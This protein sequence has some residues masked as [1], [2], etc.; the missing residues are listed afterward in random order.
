MAFEVSSVNPLRRAAYTDPAIERAEQQLVFAGGWIALL[1]AHQLSDSGDQVPVEAAGLPLVAVRDRDGQVRVFHNVCRHRASLVVPEPVKQQPT[2]RCPYHG[3]AYALDGSLRATPLWDGQRVTGAGVLDRLRLGLR[4]VRSGVWSDVVWIDLSGTAPPFEEHVAPL[5]R[6]WEGYDMAQFRVAHTESGQIDANWKL[7][8]EA[9]VENYH[10]SF[11]HEKLP[12]RLDSDAP[13]FTEVAEGMMFGFITESDDALRS[14]TPLVP[15]RDPHTK[16]IDNLC[17][18]FPNGQQNLFGGLA[19]RTIWVP[20]AID[21]CEWRTSWYMIGDAATDLA[22]RPAR[23][24]VV[25]FWRQ[26]R[27]EDRRTIEWM[28]RGRASP[29]ADDLILSPFW[30][31]AIGMF[32]TLWRARMGDAVDA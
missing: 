5:T 16:R 3:W 7:A 6:M 29:V 17:Y 12:A 24:E 25:A 22:H 18:L 21:R 9:S 10:E 2:L 4:E 28:Q 13:T 26:L 14:E 31:R 27:E 30:E 15:L 23:D 20:L 32:H 8:I 19:V 11:V 1:F